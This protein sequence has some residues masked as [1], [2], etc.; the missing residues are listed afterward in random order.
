MWHV[1]HAQGR[2]VP[3]VAAAV[4]R[5]CE[6]PVHPAQLIETWASADG[7]RVTIRPILPQD[8]A[9]E[10]AFLNGL[11][12]QTR[13]QRVLSTRGLLPGEL[14]RLTRIDYRRDMALV[15]TIVIDGAEVQIGVARYVRGAGGHTAEFAIV[16]ADVWQRRGLGEKLMMKLVDV[17]ARH[18][19]GS[20]TGMVLSTNVRMLA[21]ARKLGFS[22]RLDPQDATVAQV[23]RLLEPAPAEQAV[24]FDA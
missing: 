24:V 20:L 2:T 15:A 21:L 5:A 17:A 16:I 4:E 7:T 19:L 3:V 10:L 13:Y 8:A 11:S 12:L 22:V 14:R 23:R 1:P 18:G 9:M 6:R